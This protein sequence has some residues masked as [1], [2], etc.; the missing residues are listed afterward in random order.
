MRSASKFKRITLTAR[1][2]MK[3]MIALLF[4]NIIVLSVWTAL[5]PMQ[6]KTIVMGKDRFDRPEETYG[7]CNSRDSYI[8][9]ATLGVINFGTAF[10][11]LMQA[12]QARNI[13]T[14]LSESIYIFRV[15]YIILYGSCLGFPV[16]IIAQDKIDA[17]YFVWAG[18]TFLICSSILL[19]IFIPK[20]LATREKEPTEA[21]LPARWQIMVND[22]SENTDEKEGIMIYNTSSKVELEKECAKLKQLCIT[23]SR[24]QGLDYDALVRETVCHSAREELG[25]S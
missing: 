24:N 3:P 4:L 16:L 10:Y 23:L 17:Y 22:E 2:V 5:D 18:L 25:Q 6:Y 11:T 8:Y 15:L 1:D 20:I 19:L 7:M 21:N 9:V 12:Y 14:E 13:S